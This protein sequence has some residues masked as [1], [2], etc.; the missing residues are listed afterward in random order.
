MKRQDWLPASSGKEA[1][2]QTAMLRSLIGT[3][4]Q[5]ESPR[6]PEQ[7]TAEPLIVILFPAYHVYVL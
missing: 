2:A 5:H 1:E 6:P 4:P 7:E 3:S